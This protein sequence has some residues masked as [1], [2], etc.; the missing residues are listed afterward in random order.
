[1]SMNLTNIDT[2]LSRSANTQQNFKNNSQGF[3]NVQDSL[4]NFSAAR[5]NF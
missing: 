1:M 4:N 3:G 5:D 2:A